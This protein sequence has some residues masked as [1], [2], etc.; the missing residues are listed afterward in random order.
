MVA[1]ASLTSLT[2]AR[3]ARMSV[4][5]MWPFL[6]II[7]SSPGPMTMRV[8]ERE[9]I[10]PDELARPDLRLRH[11]LVMDLLDAYVQQTGDTTVGLR[12]GATIDCAELDP[13]VQASRSCATFREAI[14]CSARYMHLLSDAAELALIER[15]GGGEHALWRFTVNDGVRQPPSANDF[16]IMT[17]AQFAIRHVHVE[18]PAVEIH[19]MH[20]APA[21]LAPYAV[22]SASAL[23]FGMPHNGFLIEASQLDR[24]MRAAN[25]KMQAAFERYA[26]EQTQRSSA[27][28]RGRTRD[29]VVAELRRGDLGMESVAAALSMSTPTLRRRLEDEGTTFT[30]LVDDVR[31]ELAERYLREPGRSISEIAFLLGFAHAPAFH[32]AFRRWTGVTPSQHRARIGAPAS[33]TRVSDTD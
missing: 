22:F 25:A 31:K 29:I 23:K 20:D 30:D 24:P 21:D 18:K 8:L 15:F 7:G 5:L 26:L 2:Y 19:F 1:A 12:A 14:Q 3:E 9:G 6:R 27:G 17:A 28:V 32:K 11:R 4:R 33:S 10:D 16:C 13:M